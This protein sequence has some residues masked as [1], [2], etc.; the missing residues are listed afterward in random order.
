MGSYSIVPSDLL[1]LYQIALFFFYDPFPVD[2]ETIRTQY[3]IIKT[4]ICGAVQNAA[5]FG[6]AWTILYAI[7]SSSV[8]LLYL[9]RSQMVDWAAY[10]LFGLV[11]VILITTKIWTA[12]FFTL[13][14][15]HL[16]FLD[17]VILFLAICAYIAIGFVADPSYS[18]TFWLPS[19][20]MI[21]PLL[22][23][24]YALYLNGAVA[25]H[26]IDYSVK[27]HAL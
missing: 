18:G 4:K 26:A 14:N 10:T 8:F 2:R 23:M 1:V 20:L 9:Q 25:Y 16:A 7:M 19:T 11:A 3:S 6:I 21:F 5:I 27:S 24:C 22:W 17:E 15:P 12:I 13:T